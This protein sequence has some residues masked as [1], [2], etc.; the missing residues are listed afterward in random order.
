MED[1]LVVI[2]R[3]RSLA[4]TVAV[5]YISVRPSVV[6]GMRL[7][8]Q[9]SHLRIFCARISTHV[10]CLL[11]T[12]SI[13]ILAVVDGRFVGVDG[14]GAEQTLQSRALRW[15]FATSEV[16]TAKPGPDSEVT[17]RVCI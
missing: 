1:Q 3:L 5:M 7:L 9:R 14:R 8:S 12:T 16:G 4:V 6:R 15:K 11:S 17:F 2:V 10:V 13:P